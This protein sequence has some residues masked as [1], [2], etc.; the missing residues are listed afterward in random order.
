MADKTAEQAAIDLLTAKG[1]AVLT[2]LES[3]K[4]E[5][6]IETTLEDEAEMFFGKDTEEAAVY[7]MACGKIGWSCRFEGWVPTARMVETREAA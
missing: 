6:L 1:Y 4:I 7:S 3:S 2:S 5:T